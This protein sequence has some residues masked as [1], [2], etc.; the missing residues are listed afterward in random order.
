I[1]NYAFSG[2][3]NIS[4]V[5]IPS[6]VTTI[7]TQAFFGTSLSS[8]IVPK[9]VISI[10]NGAFAGCANLASIAVEEGNTSYKSV[11]NN[12]YTISGNNLLQ[13][14]VANSQTTFT[15]PDGVVQISSYSFFG[16][17]ALESV[18]L[19]ESV[20]GIGSYAFGGCENLTAV[21]FKH[22]SNWRR[23]TDPGSDATVNIADVRIASPS[24]MAKYLTQEYADKSFFRLI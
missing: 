22:M 15:V 17:L 14:A 8:I 13:Y 2:C 12:L 1:G 6:S 4:S 19:A 24:T 10:G 20:M 11:D 7:G 3:V 23:S 18:T 21:T 16:C 9:N 5:T